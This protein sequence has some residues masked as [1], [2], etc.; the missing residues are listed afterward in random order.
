MSKG[1]KS[2]IKKE[3]NMCKYCNKVGFLF[4]FDMDNPW[5]FHYDHEE[6]IFVFER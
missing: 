4:G 3:D 6:K 1:V 2:I 5:K